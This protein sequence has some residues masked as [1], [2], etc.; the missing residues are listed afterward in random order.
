MAPIGP[1]PVITFFIAFIETKINA[2]TLL[3]KH[4]V[5]QLEVSISALLSS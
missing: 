1:V 5:T 3:Y 2:G 4:L